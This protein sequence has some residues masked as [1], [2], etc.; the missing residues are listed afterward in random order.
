MLKI[1]KVTALTLFIL[2]LLKRFEIQFRYFICKEDE[3]PHKNKIAYATFLQDYFLQHGH[4]LLYFVR[5][6]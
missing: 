3:E 1:P 6:R 2:I 5:K 4:Q